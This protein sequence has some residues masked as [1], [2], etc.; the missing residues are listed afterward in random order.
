MS[1]ANDEERNR[2]VRFLFSG[3]AGTLNVAR[4][5]VDTGQRKKFLEDA[6]KFYFEAVKQ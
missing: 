6:R 3:M 4:L 5:I 1:G 2:K